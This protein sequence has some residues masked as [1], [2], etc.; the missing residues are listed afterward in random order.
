MIPIRVN[1][2]IKI[3]PYVTYFLIG[4]NLLVFIWE[5][6]LPQ[7]ELYS[8]IWGLALNPCQVTQNFFSLETLLD[9]FRTMF[10]HG[11]WVHL[12]GNMLFLWVFGPHM[13][14]FF[15]R[16]GFSVFYLMTGLFAGFAHTLFHSSWCVPLIGAS[17]AISG[18]LGAFIILY[19]LTKIQS[20]VLFFRVP[21]GVRDIKAAW[22]LGY[23]FI[24]DLI[25]GIG[26]LAVADA[27]T[28]SGVVVWAHVRGFTTGALFA[29]FFTAFI[30]PLPP[31]E[32]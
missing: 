19:P 25:A 16:L 13:E 30:K 8:A 9:S 20:V 1:R 21:V 26:T 3:T 29:F 18:I 22:L 32:Y 4:V 27:V 11:S 24:L 12:V 5:I 23:I 6:T 2:T 31:L 7:R 15:G 17:G 10:L 14:A 28:T